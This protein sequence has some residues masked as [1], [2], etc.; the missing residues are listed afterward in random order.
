MDRLR[1]QAGGA[2]LRI[3]VIGCGRIAQVAHLP[4]IA[5]SPSVTLVGV[6]DPSPLLSGGVARRYDVDSYTDTSAL[7]ARRDLEAVLVA[8]P[9]RFHRELATAALDHGLPVLVEKP[10]AATASEAKDLLDA[11]T[12]AGRI[13]QVGAM[14][15]HD[16]GLRFAREA[17]PGI[18]EIL[19]A[20]FWYRLPSSLRSSTEA[21]LFPAQVVDTQV[22]AVESGFKAD[23]EVYLLRTHGAHVFDTVRHL[24]GEVTSMT[25]ECARVGDD[26]Q[27]QGSI[28]TVAGL[29]SYA[30]TANAHADYSEGIDIFGSGRT[31][32]GSVVLPVLSQGKAA[33]LRRAERRGG[34]PPSSVP[35]TP[36]SGSWRRSPPPSAWGRPPN[37]TCTTV[38]GHC[39]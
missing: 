23:R 29:A 6:S 31:D 16:P 5:K 34:R 27:W 12:R 13:V 18:G 39:R 20:V 17:V 37:P 19:S 7:L 26:L 11:A 36:T 25:T 28:R 33:G 22:R 30:I 9:D 21:A 8:V 2:P 10:A 35:S 14:R 3:G 4:A 32:P 38:F 15:R 1:D 24:L